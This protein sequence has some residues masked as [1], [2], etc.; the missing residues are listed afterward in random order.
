MPETE[1]ELRMDCSLDMARPESSICALALLL[2]STEL[3][4]AKPATIKTEM[5]V[6]AMANSTMV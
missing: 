5:M 2:V 4:P 3:T 1:L 6:S